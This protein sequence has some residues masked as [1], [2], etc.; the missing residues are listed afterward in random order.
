MIDRF[1]S[2]AVAFTISLGFAM[3]ALGQTSPTTS[4]WDKYKVLSER[5]LFLKDRSRRNDRAKAPVYPPEH[6]LVLTG[7]VRQGDEY[8][9]FLEDTRSGATSRVKANG[10]AAQ[11]RIA[12][13]G[14]DYVEYEK[15]GKAVRIEVGRSFEGGAAV[16]GAQAAGEVATPGGAAVAG[17]QAAPQSGGSS[18]EKAALDRL[19]QR[20]LQELNKK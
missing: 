20:R 10:Q 11:G 6:F 14:L 15:D 4:S 8:V 5:N 16:A 17:A 18:D 1:L 12:R 9:A 7:V 2:A 13:L 19:K 3:T